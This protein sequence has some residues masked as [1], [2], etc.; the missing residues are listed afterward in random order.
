MFARLNAS[1]GMAEWF[2]AVLLKSTVGFTL[3]VG[4]NPTPSDRNADRFTEGDTGP[5]IA[6][7]N[8]GTRRIDFC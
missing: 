7:E 5:S 8:W 2:K 4:S 1:G 6:G 3:T